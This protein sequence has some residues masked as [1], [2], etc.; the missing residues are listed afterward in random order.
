[1]GAGASSN[2]GSPGKS[3]RSL[4]EKRYSSNSMEDTEAKLCEEIFQTM[5]QVR[6]DPWLPRLR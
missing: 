6:K 3:S 4:G 2:P 1:M 5:S